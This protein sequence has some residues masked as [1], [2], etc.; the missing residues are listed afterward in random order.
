[1]RRMMIVLALTA[2]AALLG[3]AQA[4]AHGSRAKLD[5]RKTAVGTILVNGNG[6]T[7]YAFTRD[8]RNKDMCVQISGCSG[9]WPMVTTS[10][11]PIAGRGVKSSLIGTIS[12]RRGVQQVTYAGHPLYTYVGDSAPG[13]TSYVDFSE[14][15]G[16]WPALSA[17]G[18]EVK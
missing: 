11:K 17:S 5:L 2:T 14:F 8:P 12:I 13:Q 7:M 1:M 4:G 10:G 18:G 15:G 16:R 9:V 6:F 3:V